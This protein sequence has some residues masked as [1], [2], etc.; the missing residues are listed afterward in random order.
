MAVTTI[1]Q[2]FFLV[3]ELVH[4]PKNTA[5]RIN[6]VFTTWLSVFPKQINY[7]YPSRAAIMQTYEDKNGIGGFRDEFGRGFTRVSIQGTF[8]REPRR[9]GVSLKD[10]WLRL[11]EFR[12][13]IVKLSH[14]THQDGLFDPELFGMSS[15]M[16]SQVKR[17][18]ERTRGI[19]FD[20]GDMFVVN[21]YDFFNDESFAVDIREFQILE[22][23][24]SNNLPIY[25]LQM[26]E[27]G[28]I[29]E[30]V[31]RDP[32]LELLLATVTAANFI[33]DKINL[34]VDFLSRALR[35]D[36]VA[37]LVAG[38]DIAT[39]ARLDSIQSAQQAMQL[40]AGVASKARDA[41]KFGKTQAGK[42]EEIF[43]GV[44]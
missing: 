30:P 32:M 39:N 28:A 36:D 44:F 6:S 27:I 26:Q 24:T 20:R 34:G 19:P 5:H 38:Y 1:P 37:M 43:E 16:I 21:Y 7:T 17:K 8:G 14:L 2:F 10:G 3:F 13:V 22:T 18:L 29:V 35:L 23:V 4:L 33:V 40:A 25:S 9:Q 15:D 41:F 31:D 42:V 11:K 12:E